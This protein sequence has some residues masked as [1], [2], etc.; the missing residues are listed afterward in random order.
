MRVEASLP[1][2]WK[3]S[4]YVGSIFGGSMLSASDPVLMIQL[5][6]ILGDDFV[7]WDKAVHMRFKRPARERVQIVFKFSADEIEQIRQQAVQHGEVDCEKV[8]ELTNTEGTVFAV[9]TKTLYIAT[10]AHYKAKRAQ[11]QAAANS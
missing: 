11:K 7:V 10:K 4:N 3:N 5:M 9:A 2:S 8:I 1:L 6:Q